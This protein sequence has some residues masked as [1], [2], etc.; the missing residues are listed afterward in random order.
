[1]R[2]RKWDF[3][4]E[5][6]KQPVREEILSRFAEELASELEG[7]PPPLTEWAS[8]ELRRRL[9]AGFEKG[10]LRPEVLR[11]SL[12]LARLDLAREDEAFEAR[13]R[14]D[15]PRLCTEASDRAALELAVLFVTE[16]CLSLKEWAEGARLTRADL[17]RALELAERRLF[18]AAPG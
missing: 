1:M 2:D 15:V 14:N 5:K 3:L 16:R 6:E 7:W 9:A 18:R 13:M 12:E 4:Y 17:S 10:A 8:E 11:L